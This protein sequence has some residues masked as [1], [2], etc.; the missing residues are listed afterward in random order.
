MRS[1]HLNLICAQF[2]RLRAGAAVDV[3]LLRRRVRSD[4]QRLLLNRRGAFPLFFMFRPQPAH[5]A[6]ARGIARVAQPARPRRDLP[7][8]DARPLVASPFLQSDGVKAA[9]LGRKNGAATS[10]PP[11]PVGSLVAV[12][13]F[14]HP[15][16]VT[17]LAA[18]VRIVH[19][20]LSRASAAPAPPRGQ[21]T[22][23]EKCLC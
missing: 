17:S 12:A 23:F 1:R 8:V 5:H 6:A 2:L 11:I 15:C 13:R 4:A 22:P 20:R 19:A 18:G 3:L 7:G 10:H 14:H 21:L 16:A 9:R